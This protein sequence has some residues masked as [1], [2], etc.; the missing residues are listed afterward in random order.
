M[1]RLPTWPLLFLLLAAFLGAVPAR[2]ADPQWQVVAPVRTPPVLYQPSGIALNSSGQM[3]VTDAANGTIQKL[4]PTGGPLATWGSKSLRQSLDTSFPEMQG[5]EYIVTPLGIAVAPSGTQ[6]V[7][8][9]E[10]VC[11]I[12]VC[13]ISRNNTCRAYQILQKRSPSGGVFLVGPYDQ[14]V[15]QL[16][17]NGTRRALRGN[18]Q[19]DVLA[20]PLNLAVD[21]SGNVYVTVQNHIKKLRPD[22]TTAATW[23]DPGAPSGIAIAPNGHIYVSDIAGDVRELTATGKQVRQWGTTGRK[24]GQFRTG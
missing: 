8:F 21:T 4:S 22:G 6:L 3:F 17:P 20:D 7:S 14:T 2:A 9:E 23:K 11:S 15:Q 24:P 5:I 13:S 10:Q 1:V 19:S 12:S 16:G 18:E